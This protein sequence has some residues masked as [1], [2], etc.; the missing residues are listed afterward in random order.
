MRIT[1]SLFIFYFV[2]IIGIKAQSYRPDTT[3]TYATFLKQCQN[4]TSEKRQEIWMVSFW[5]SNLNA[6][7]RVIPELEETWQLFR[8]KPVR[9][10]S[11]SVDRRRLGWERV[12]NYYKMQG[13]QLWLNNREDYEF[14]KQAFK[15]NSLPAIFVVNTQG[16]IRR[17]R[18]TRELE[19]LLDL[20]T[21]ALPNEGYN[22]NNIILSEDGNE[23]DTNPFTTNEDADT[24]WV[25]YTV[26]KGDNLTQIAKKYNTSVAD[27]RT[28][29]DISGDLIRVG[30]RLKV[31]AR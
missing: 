10:V 12:L 15:H 6:S 28:N 3:L 18:D 2:T 19:D 14:L 17:V 20:E 26:R 7:L 31:R 9:F 16:Q 22:S 8:N 24:N 29:N 21:R 11:I 4:F 25:Y 5:A 23:I 30:Q 27:L 13:E 1:L